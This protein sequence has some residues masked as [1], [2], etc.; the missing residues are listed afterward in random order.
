MLAAELSHCTQIHYIFV[1][2][3]KHVFYV[4]TIVTATCY[5]KQFSLCLLLTNDSFLPPGKKASIFSALQD[6]SRCEE[7]EFIL[8]KTEVR[9]CRQF[10]VDFV[11]LHP[12]E[13]I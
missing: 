12:R 11:Y 7:M 1:D 2:T 5:K 9:Q 8:T 6:L 13:K 4:L 3:V 10:T